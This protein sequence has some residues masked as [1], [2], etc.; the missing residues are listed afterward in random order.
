MTCQN[1]VTEE[2][3]IA[4]LKIGDEVRI[5]YFEFLNGRRDIIIA[6]VYEG[7]ASEN[8]GVSGRDE[9]SY[10]R[11][12]HRMF[13]GVPEIISVAIHVCDLSMD[14]EDKT[15]DV[16]PNMKELKDNIIIYSPGIFGWEKRERIMRG[17]I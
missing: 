5:R 14:L 4:N 2:D 6:G 3:V 9:K 10:H 11:F 8:G 17:E 16:A 13:M 7:L 12:L 1:R 15:I